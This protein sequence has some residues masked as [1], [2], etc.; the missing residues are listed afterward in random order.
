MKKIT[1]AI[2]VLFMTAAAVKA[3][4]L[5]KVRS[6]YNFTLLPNSGAAK[7][8]DAKTEVDKLMADAKAGTSADAWLFKAMIYG[9]LAGDATLSAK[10][11]EANSQSLGALKKYLELDPEGKKIKEENFGGV[12]EIYQSFFN[13]GVKEYKASNWPKANEY[14]KQLVDLSSIMVSK[15][16]TSIAFD[17]TAF[18]YAG[19]SAQNAKMDDDAVKFYSAL[20]ERKIAGPDYEGVYDYVARYYLKKRDQ[21]NFQRFIQLAKD[22]YPKLGVWNDL[23]F[24]YQTENS[25]LTQLVKYFDDQD[26]AK[27]LSSM[28]YFDYGNYF[29]NDKKI[30]DLEEAQRGD[31][32]KKSA[33]AFS[34][35]YDLD[36]TN[37]LAAYNT[38]VTY[39]ALWESQAD[40]ARQ[41]KGVTAD[42]KTKRAAADKTAD[43]TV[44]KAIEWL[45]KAY[46]SLAAK[47]GRSNVERASLNKSIDLLYNAY[48]YKRERTKGVAP[49][50]YDKY[51]AKMKLYDSLHNKF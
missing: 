39:F 26:A 41:L 3:Q 12:N 32:T 34:R 21:A 27:K 33:Y 50:D 9:K 4:D 46:T 18:L 51:D 37:L 17:T 10:Y 6:A 42:I 47:T 13:L 24:S 22:A 45:E 7:L 36:T 8:E 20:A 48:Q 40:A 23:E 44:D 11:P 49:K 29:I 28:E 14:F 30:K 19:V 2:A 43:A 1:I 35:A 15:N 5:K 25:D 38:G 31:Y 16:W